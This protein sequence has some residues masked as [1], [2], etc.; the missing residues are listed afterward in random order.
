VARP[1]QITRENL[2]PFLD[3]REP[4]SAATMAAALGVN[5]STIVRAL[6]I[7]GKD[8]VVLGNTRNTRYAL[9]RPIRN[10]GSRWPV[11]QMDESGRAALWAE[12]E[13]LQDRSWRIIWAGSRPAWAHR[14]FSGAEGHWDGFPFFLGDIR[15]Q[16]FLGRALAHKYARS[17][18]LPENPLT[19]SDEDTLIFL[20]AMDTLG[21][22]RQ[23]VG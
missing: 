17:L 20:Q 5:R 16:G 14:F 11:Y 8:P 13:A 4:V 12:L 15:P 3:R 19:W 23:H 9:R 21:K 7:F 2:V 18:T 10:L 1:A 6:G 22:L